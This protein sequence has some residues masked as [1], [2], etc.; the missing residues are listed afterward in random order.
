MSTDMKEAINKA[1]NE[2]PAKKKGHIKGHKQA[3]KEGKSKKANIDTTKVYN[4]TVKWFD[5]RKGFGFITDEEGVDHFVHFSGIT[6]GRR[7][8]AVDP[9]DKVTFTLQHSKGGGVQAANVEIIVTDEEEVEY[10]DE[11]DITESY[12][13]NED[14]EHEAAYDDNDLPEGPEVEEHTETAGGVVE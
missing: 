14:V 13:N 8:I 12:A 1:M 9:D 3:N 11:E 2:T 5:I 6:R 10:E 7:F 4:G